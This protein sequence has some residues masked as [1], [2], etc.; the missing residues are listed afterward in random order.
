MSYLDLPGGRIAYDDTGSGPLV[1]AVPGL[2]DVRGLYRF[3][4]PRLVD[5]GYRV[6]TMDVRGHGQS[7]VGWDDY[8]PAAIGRDVV[9]LLRHLNAGPAVVIGESMAAASA[10]WAAGEAPD[11]VAGIA[12]SGP[13]VRDLPVSLVARLGAWAVGRSPRLWGMFY[14]SLYKTAPPPDLDD[15]LRALQ[16]NLA[17]PGRMA[18]LREMLAASKADCE[19]R[20]DSVRCPALVLMGTKDPDFKDPAAEARR[21]G[22]RLHATV[23]MVEGAG[24]YPPAEFPTETAAALLPFLAKVHGGA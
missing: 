18:A 17:E 9:A 12:L 6:A 13:A 19:A 14:K 10:V 8:S 15:Y 7:S 2:G 5:A 1:L 22:G 21:V 4:A 24:H 11:L 16:A 20:L 23:V 3:L